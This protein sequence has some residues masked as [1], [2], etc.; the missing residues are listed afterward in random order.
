MTNLTNPNDIQLVVIYLP[1]V[2]VLFLSPFKFLH[3]NLKKP[4]LLYLKRNQYKSNKR[5]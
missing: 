2:L 5:M 1:I 4:L 3:E